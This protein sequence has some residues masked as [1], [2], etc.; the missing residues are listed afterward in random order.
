MCGVVTAGNSSGI[1]DG[2]SAL[3]ITSETTAKKLGI[4]PKAYI[5][6][7]ASTALDPNLMGLGP[8]ESVQKALKAAGKSIA[9]MDLVEINE[10][11]AVQV[12]AAGRKLDV[13]WSKTNVNGGAIALGHPIGAS[14]ARLLTTLLFEM[15]KRDSENGLVTLC[16]GGGQG[17]AMVI[18]R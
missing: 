17:I 10:A 9:D 8:Y 11:F 3:A 13:D 18:S 7:Y 5:Q 12:I 16:I 4:K 14:G 2:A 1:N 6:S 15:E